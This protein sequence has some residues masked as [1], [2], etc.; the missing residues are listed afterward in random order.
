MGI[1]GFTKVFG[2]QG[3]LKYKDF[4]GMTVAIDAMYQLYRTAHPFNT[5]GQSNLLAPDGSI[6]NHLNGLIALIFNLK[7]VGATQLWIFDNPTENHNSLKSIEQERRKS[8]K[9]IAAAKLKKIKD[10]DLFSDSEDDTNPM[11]SHNDSNAKQINKYERAAFTLDIYMIEDLKYILHCLGVAWIEAPAGYEAEQLA[12][13]LTNKDI[14]NQR[15]NIVLTTDI[16]CLLFG[17]KEMAKQDKQKFY[18]YT[19]Q[20]ILDEHKI[21]QDDLIKT[22]I[23]LGCDFADKTPKVGV[24]TVLKRL[25]N[26]E[27]TAE[28]FKAFNYFKTPICSDSINKLKWNIGDVDPF[29]DSKKNIELFE[30]LTQAKGFNTT[31]MASR[32][33]A[34]A[35][36]LH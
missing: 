15:A 35:I 33:K 20:N 16:D 1:K 13:Y 17:A 29:A 3:E 23:A 31:K 27:L 19:L 30:W 24:K 26:I 6:T 10:D 11:A 36:H 34:A 2:H 9:N 8:C 21:N 32:F 14:D 7:K 25:P 22:G 4:K 12:S 18:K 28:Q 5:A